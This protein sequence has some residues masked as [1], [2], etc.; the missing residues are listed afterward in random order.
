MDNLRLIFQPR[1]LLTFQILRVLGHRYP[2]QVE[3][4]IGKLNRST[5]KK[6]SVSAGSIETA[7]GDGDVGR[8]AFNAETLSSLVATTFVGAKLVHH[9]PFKVCARFR[10]R[11]SDKA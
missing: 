3:A 1:S 7:G 6:K 10:P 11:F 2:D 5:S 4:S 9:V 8:D